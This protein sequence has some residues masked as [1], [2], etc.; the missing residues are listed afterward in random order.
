MGWGGASSQDEEDPHTSGKQCSRMSSGAVGS[1]QC[2]RMAQQ[3]QRQLMVQLSLGPSRAALLEA[4]ASYDTEEVKRLLSIGIPVNCVGEADITPLHRAAGA[5]R[6]DNVRVLLEAGADVAARDLDGE[7]PLHASLHHY[8][9]ELQKAPKHAG[10][11]VVALLA[12]HS[13][14]LSAAS[15]HGEQP[16]VMATEFGDRV[17]PGLVKA[18]LAAMP[19][20]DIQQ[21]AGDGAELA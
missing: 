11:A 18:L 5:W 9:V 10:P 15:Q 8:S 16:L 6:L 3:G 14:D 1:L 19:P 4:A 20:E 2:M 17:G 21:Q 7:T 12:Q 13:A